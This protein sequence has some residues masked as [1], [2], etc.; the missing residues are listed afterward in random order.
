MHHGL[1]V[2]AQSKVASFKPSH[3]LR[4]SKPWMATEQGFLGLS[5]LF[6]FLESL[7]Y[8]PTKCTWLSQAGHFWLRGLFDLLDLWVY[9]PMSCTWPSQ[10]DRFSLLCGLVLDLVCRY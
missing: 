9:F 4:C 6:D 5:D 3:L 8:F 1:G 2:I 10:A 7:V